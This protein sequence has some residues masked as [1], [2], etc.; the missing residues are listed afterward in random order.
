MDDRHADA[1]FN[2]G[3]AHVGVDRVEGIP[4]MA[5]SVLAS[6]VADALPEY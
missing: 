4:L 3:L 1:A 2:V 6:E 5:C